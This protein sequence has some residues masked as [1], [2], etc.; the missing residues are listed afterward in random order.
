MY[1]WFEKSSGNQINFTLDNINLRV[2]PNTYQNVLS[3]LDNEIVD[4]GLI[5]NDETTDLLHSAHEDAVDYVDNEV[6]EWAKTGNGNLRIP[7]DKFPLVENQSQFLNSLVQHDI[8]DGSFDTDVVLRGA[9]FDVPY[10]SGG[11]AGSSNWDVNPSFQTQGYSVIGSLAPTILDTQKSSPLAIGN[12]TN[13]ANLNTPATL[14]GRRIVDDTT[15][16]TSSRYFGFAFK[17]IDGQF[18]NGA[19]PLTNPFG[20]I[21]P[22]RC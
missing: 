9:I 21:R 10:V 13:R 7:A 6:E 5:T 2:L 12:I 8:H 11:R 15:G 3:V 14:Y 18:W 17:V 22:L 1:V 19:N 4:R 16:A 20:G